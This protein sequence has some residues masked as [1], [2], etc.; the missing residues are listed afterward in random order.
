MGIYRVDADIERYFDDFVFVEARTPEDAVRKANEHPW[1]KEDRGGYSNP[2]LLA[3]NRWEHTVDEV[4]RMIDVL[5]KLRDSFL[6]DTPNEHLICEKIRQVQAMCGDTL[7]WIVTY[8]NDEIRPCW[9]NQ[10]HPRS[11]C[12]ERATHRVFPKWM[13]HSLSRSEYNNLDFCE[14][15]ANSYAAESGDARIVKLDIEPDVQLITK[16]ALTEVVDAIHNKFHTAQSEE[17]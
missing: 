11:V 16:E 14:K 2:V 7:S 15:H 9:E 5:T 1:V 17:N 3:E 6:T 8:G 10:R 12:S 4:Y 13:E